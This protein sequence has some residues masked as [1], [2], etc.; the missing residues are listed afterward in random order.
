M[1]LIEVMVTMAII[2]IVSLIMVSGFS[3]M[4]NLDMKN[5]DRVNTDAGL[6]EEIAVTGVSEDPL[7]DS[8]YSKDPSTGPDEL[9]LTNPALPSGS[10][11]IP[12][13]GKRYTDEA[14]SG[15]TIFDFDETA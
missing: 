7:S 12:I 5:T 2:V 9:T 6:S 11:D 14:G 10:L 8:T 1:T 4:A 13:I 3:A 15:F